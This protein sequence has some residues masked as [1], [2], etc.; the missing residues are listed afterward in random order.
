VESAKPV[1]EQLYERL[2][3]EL[4]ERNMLAVAS[5]IQAALIAGYKQGA[6][7]A[8]FAAETEARQNGIELTLHLDLEVKDDDYDPWIE[9]YGDIE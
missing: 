8:V 5:A 9:K 4:S 2:E 7:M 6:A 3:G 1:V